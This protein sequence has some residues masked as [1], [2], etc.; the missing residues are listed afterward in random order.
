MTRR[1][2]LEAD[3]QKRIDAH[4][5]A[6]TEFWGDVYG[7]NDVESKRFRVR[8][9]WARRWIERLE[10]PA[11][12]R[13]LD[14]GAG[15]GFGTLALA[16]LGFIVDAIDS[17]DDMVRLIR[18]AAAADGLSERVRAQQGDAHALTAAAETYDII[19]A[20]GVIPWLHSPERALA[21]MARVL[22]P[23]GHVIVSCENRFAATSVIEPMRSP[24]LEEVRRFVAGRLRR[25]GL[26][27]AP[28]HG[29]RA[30]TLSLQAFDRLLGAAGLRKQFA[31]TY[32][33]GPFS[34]LN[35]KLPNRPGLAIDGWLQMLADSGFP[36]VRSAG[37]GYIVLAEKVDIPKSV[38][39]EK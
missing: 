38:G 24:I 39:A 17:V 15:A 21:E 26:R 37:V 8:L 14:I 35:R 30:R 23:R 3:F 20:L 2:P 32:G 27:R 13:A 29:P 1:P 19:L 11:G 16:R 10:L 25:A 4:F 36:V 22:K 28:E 6:T 12:A 7:R 33:F 18:R 31:H 5:A 34:F 9:E